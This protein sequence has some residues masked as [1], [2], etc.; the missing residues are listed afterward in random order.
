M[1]L[2]ALEQAFA[3]HIFTGDAAILPEVLS[4]PGFS[5]HQRLGVYVHAYYARLDGVLHTDFP[6]LAALLG[7]EAEPVF[8]AYVRARPS[9][10]FTL[11][12]FGAAL[13]EFLRGHAATRG[14]PVLAQLA[15][16]EWAFCEAF[17]A[18]D[19]P[20]AGEQDAARVP[21]ESWPGLRFRLHPS[22]QR[23]RTDFNLPA[24]WRALKDAPLTPVAPEAMSGPLSCLVWRQE[25][26]TQYRS[27]EPDEAAA[28]AA[29]AEGGGFAEVCAALMPSCAPETLALR[30]A[31][32]LK[33][34]LAQ[35]L[36]AELVLA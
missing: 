2:A 25:L 30:A 17:D 28:L 31:G 21:P 1:K 33:T 34:W 27:L 12:D 13:P 15:A 14:R 18:E 16:F 10:S 5:A 19:A 3:R 36:I 26:A 22:V 23:V 9:T 6:A 8:T 20:V 24:L 29:I 35:G 32:L 11:R 4:T 7:E